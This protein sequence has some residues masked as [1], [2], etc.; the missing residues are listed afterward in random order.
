[1]SGIDGWDGL[2][3]YRTK[4][5]CGLDDGL[6]GKRGPRVGKVVEKRE[7]LLVNRTE[8]KVKKSVRDKCRTLGLREKEIIVLMKHKKG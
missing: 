6:Q 3:G 4:G 7:D 1:M 2:G 5:M 8:K